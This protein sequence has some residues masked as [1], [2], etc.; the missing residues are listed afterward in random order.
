M[1]AEIGYWTYIIFKTTHLWFIKSACL[2]YFQ[3]ALSSHF[4]PFIL[5]CIKASLETAC[6]FLKTHFNWHYLLTSFS[7]RS[8]TIQS[9]IYQRTMTQNFVR[10]YRESHRAPRMN[11]VD[12]CSL[13][14][15]NVQYNTVILAL[16]MEIWNIFSFS[17]S[18]TL[19][20][21]A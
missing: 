16:W 3:V 20:S 8:N 7:S 5:L 19:I 11:F 6:S 13:V 9:L 14:R 12:E 15:K 10:V 17:Y 1:Q 18:P 4:L 21:L 2:C